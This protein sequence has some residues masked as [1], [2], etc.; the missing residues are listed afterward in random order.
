MIPEYHPYV[1]PYKTTPQLYKFGH[2]FGN[3]P[4]DQ[5]VFQQDANWLDYLTEKNTIKHNPRSI[6]PAYIYD[7]MS[8]DRELYYLDFYDYPQEDWTIHK[9]EDGVDKMIF[10]SFFLPSFWRPEESLGKSLAELH[11]PVPGLKLPQKTLE[12]CTNNWFVR[13]VWSIVYNN[14][15]NFHPNLENQLKFDPQKPDWFI[16]VERQVIVGM[17][18]INGFL[19]VVKP[20]I[21]KNPK[22]KELLFTIRGMSNEHK[23]YKRITPE[24]EEYL[25]WLNSKSYA[26]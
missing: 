3:G 18:R 24:F 16:R 13:F 20:F 12:S 21:V 4:Y 15:L 9:I 7:I 23:S 1:L 8:V 11:G 19:F 17:P 6:D 22:I 25:S 10:N 26:E 5:K 14:R 2:D